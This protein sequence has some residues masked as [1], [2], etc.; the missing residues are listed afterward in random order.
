MSEKS[1]QAAETFRN[2]FN[3][4]QSVLSVFAQD[5]G[6]T[7]DSCLRLAS[8]FGSGI[9]RMQQTC[10]AVTGALMVI[11][12]KYG[13]GKNGTEEDKTHAYKLSEQFIAEFRKQHNTICCLE[14][15]DGLDMNTPEGKAEIQEREL[16]RNN[17]SKYVKFAVEITESILTG[18]R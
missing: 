9:A 18:E 14:L 3:C 11:G 13:K 4:S 7:K 2:G 10:G 15:L 6:L 1:K 5:F 17:C 16:F 8:P 12:L